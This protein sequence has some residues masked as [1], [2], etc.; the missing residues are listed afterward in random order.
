MASRA[1]RCVCVP[2]NIQVTDNRCYG[3]FLASLHRSAWGGC[4]AGRVIQQNQVRG[5][6][7]AGAINPSFPLERGLWT[8][9]IQ[10]QF[11]CWVFGKMNVLNILFQWLP[12]CAAFMCMSLLTS[13]PSQSPHVDL[14]LSLR[15]TLCTSSTKLCNYIG[16]LITK[17]RRKRGRAGKQLPSLLSWGLGLCVVSFFFDCR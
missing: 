6:M 17:G 4:P 5:L 16:N 11:W 3:V 8:R 15:H 9:N 13:L 10:Y 7:V 14:G 1:A 2:E 12:S